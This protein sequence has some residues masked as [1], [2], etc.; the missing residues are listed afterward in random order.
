[1]ESTLLCSVQIKEV[2]ATAD[3]ANPKRKDNL[4][5]KNKTT[6]GECH[7]QADHVKK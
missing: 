6:E 7:G 3:E 5:L 2:K 1:M 4:M